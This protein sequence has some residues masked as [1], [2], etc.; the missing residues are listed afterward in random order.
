MS[1][2]QAEWSEQDWIAYGNRVKKVRE[3]IMQLIQE[4]QQVATKNDMT[5][6]LD[7]IVKLDRWK[8]QMENVAAKNIQ[9]EI[10]TRIFYGRRIGGDA[11]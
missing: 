4:G 1:N 9:G 8:S 2:K 7:A 11:E 6:L 3:E 10:L 5:H